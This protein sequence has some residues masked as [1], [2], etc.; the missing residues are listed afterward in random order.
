MV[1]LDIKVS[2][3][4][5]VNAAQ[6]LFRGNNMK[7]TLFRD[8]VANYERRFDSNRVKLDFTSWKYYKNEKGQDV[9][10]EI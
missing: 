9:K 3:N 1:Y 10:E 8:F 4:I 2:E 6:D 7:V 5:H